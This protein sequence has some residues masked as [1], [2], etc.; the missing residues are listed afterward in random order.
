[1]RVRELI[2]KHW[3]L[4]KALILAGVAVTCI[5]IGGFL[6]V[7]IEVGVIISAPVF[8]F[9]VL[10]TLIPVYIAWVIS[11]LTFRTSRN[12]FE[13]AFSNGLSG[14]WVGLSWSRYLIEQG[15]VLESFIKTMLSVFMIFYG[16]SVMIEAAMARK[17]AK[18]WGNNREFSFLAILL[19]PFIYGLLE[20]NLVTL[21][22]GIT[23]FMLFCLLFIILRQVV[24]EL[25][26]GLADARK[27]VQKKTI[28]K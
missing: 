7:I 24:P 17:A 28:K 18:V 13:S 2:K 14:L 25:P 11:E 12:T 16:L 6:P 1:M 9:E 15:I 3:T 10:W 4:S 23:L 8:S 26:G 5:L 22:A 21:L 27:P 20:F 19:T